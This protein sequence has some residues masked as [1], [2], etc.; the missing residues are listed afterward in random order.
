MGKDKR[1]LGLSDAERSEI[2]ILIRKRYSHREIARVLGRSPNTI[3][4]EIKVNSVVNKNTGKLEYIATKA[5]AKARVSRRS[6]RF[7][8]Y[9]I[10]QNKKLR[11]FIIEKLKPPNDWSPKVIAG[12]L[13]DEQTVLPYVSSPQIYHWL[14]SSLGQPYCQYLCTKR[15]HK[16]KR[17]KK[18]ERVMIPDRKPI[19]ERPKI[20]GG[21]TEPGDW[22]FDSVVSGKR[23]KSTFALAVAQERATRLV[24][25]TLVPNL[26]PVPYAKAI[27]RLVDGLLVNT[28]T[29]DNG[30]ENKQHKLITKATGAVVYFTEPY[31]SWQKGGVENANRM[32]RRYFPKGTNFANVTQAQVDQA[33]KTINNKPR[34][35]LGYK[36]ALQCAIE[37][38]LLLD[39]VSY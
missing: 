24:R 36:S 37:K 22:E 25:V 34:L 33:V 19:A 18:T 28:M 7:Q 32:L 8:W 39:G 13:K 21:R 35:C 16:K 38:G 17:I 9:K 2:A 6:R 30:I 5:K 15:Y 23:S 3:S 11:D 31:S 4:R 27:N 14:F 26:K 10:E 1:Y 12:Y 20:V 29:T